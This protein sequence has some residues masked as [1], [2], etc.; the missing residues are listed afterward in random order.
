MEGHSQFPRLYSQSPLHSATALQTGWDWLTSRETEA[1]R[2][3]LT[4]PLSPSPRALEGR[5]PFSCFYHY[6]RGTSWPASIYPPVGNTILDLLTSLV[7]SVYLMLPNAFELGLW[8]S[9]SEG[10]SQFSHP[11][12]GSSAR[13]NSPAPSPVFET[14]GIIVPTKI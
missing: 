2:C 1:Q 6:S 11:R 9:F 10:S 7:M 3:F 13:L 8:T 12:C 4:P 5:L 14:V